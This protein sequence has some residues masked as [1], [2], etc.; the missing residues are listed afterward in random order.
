MSVRSRPV[1]RVQSHRPSLVN[2]ECPGLSNEECIGAP[3]RSLCPSLRLVLR[4]VAEPSLGPVLTGTL[5]TADYERCV[6]AYVDSLSMRVVESDRVGAALGDLW[7]APGLVGARYAVLVSESGVPWV[8]VIEDV[9]IQ[10]AVPFKQRGWMSL[11]V[12]VQDVDRLAA[13]LEGSPFEIHRPPADLDVS[14]DIR[15]MQV[16]GPAG[17]VLYLTQIKRPVPPFEIPVARCR[18]DHL[19]IPVMSCADRDSAQAFYERFPDCTSFRFDT[20]ITSVNSAFGDDLDRKHAVAVVQLASRT[21]VEIDQIDAA[22]PRPREIDRLPSGIASITFE[23]DSLSI[24]GF[25]FL[26]PPI[27]L[28]GQ[29]Y[30]GRR[31]ACCRGAGGELVE[32]IERR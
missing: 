5:V 9:A 26:S 7:A 1:P 27:T 14:E 3:Q 23:V 8:R 32:L 17:E 25:E 10:P 31:A 29:P 2:E 24:A 11:E 18:V 16:I 30:L 28:Q 22:V 13:E 21:M 6:A 19:F 4:M 15:A 12:A 20:I